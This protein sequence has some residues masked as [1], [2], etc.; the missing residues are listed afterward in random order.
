LEASTEN[1]VIYRRGGAR[2]KGES[3]DYRAEN[4]RVVLQNRLGKDQLTIT[5][6]LHHSEN[7]S[8]ETL[9]G[10]VVGEAPKKF[11]EAVQ[12]TKSEIMLKLQG[13]EATPD[14]MTAGVSELVRKLF[15]A[16][17]S[18]D[19]KFEK[20]TLK[21]A[22]AQFKQAHF[23]G[24]SGATQANPLEDSLEKQDQGDRGDQV[25]THGLDEEAEESKEGSPD[26]A[27]TSTEDK[28]GSKGLEKSGGKPRQAL[29][30]PSRFDKKKDEL[31]LL[32]SD[33]T[34]EATA[35]TDDAGLQALA[36]KVLAHGYRLCSQLL[37]DEE[38][39]KTI[40]ELRANARG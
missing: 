16:Y 34:S 14:E 30:A 3:G 29:K 20:D 28:G 37:S 23:S 2:T 36:L 4:I 27:T 25:E 35:I 11:F 18:N 17:Q 24:E 13:H 19:R 31:V 39:Q 38:F 9:A 5:Q 8:E 40:K 6:Y 1:P 22:V 15:E 21:N 26:Q 32:L 12:K 7:L 33:F 10:L